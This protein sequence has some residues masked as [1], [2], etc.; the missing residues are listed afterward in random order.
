M[1]SSHHVLVYL[2]P[3]SLHAVAVDWREF[4]VYGRGC[5]CSGDIFE[6]CGLLAGGRGEEVLAGLQKSSELSAHQI[7]VGE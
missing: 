6:D 1:V 4:L 2:L 3:H 7:S 5:G